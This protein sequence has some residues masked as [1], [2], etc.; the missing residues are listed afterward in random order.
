MHTRIP[1][2][3]PVIAIIGSTGTGK[4]QLAIELATRFKGE[5]INCDAVQM[6]QGLPIITNKVTTEEQ[7]GIPHHLL[8]CI[9]LEEPTWTVGQF[10]PHAMAIIEQI[11]GRGR[12]PILVGGTHYYIQSLLVKDS[13][14]G[15]DQT[16]QPELLD[17]ALDQPTEVLLQKLREVDPIMAE[18]WH[19]NERR[20]IQRS[21]EIWL[22]TG[23]KAS[24][25]YAAQKEP[26]NA[27]PSPSNIT[28]LSSDD[29]SP[30]RYEALLFWMYT[31]KDTLRARLDERVHQMVSAGLVSEVESMH[32]FRN[33][34]ELQGK[35]VDV[36]RGIWVSIGFK[37]FAEY[38]AAI[39]AGR[40]GPDVQKLKDEAIMRTQS[41]TKQY[42]KR[43]IRW[44]EYKFLNAMVRSKAKHNIFVLNSSLT[45]AWHDCVR[46]PAEVVTE[47]FLGA[48][49]VLPEASE[50]FEQSQE[51]LTPKGE[52]LSHSRHRWQKRTCDNCRITATTTE[53]WEKHI[54]SNRHRKVLAGIAKRQRLETERGLNISL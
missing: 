39:A 4:S 23:T 6:Y 41:A 44:I 12:L 53:E 24:D 38:R 40:T 15:N 22:R 3:R 49:S 52:D 33:Q 2:T 54:G 46:K 28:S 32:D 29:E 21:L 20:K 34:Q 5:I 27:S 35:E 31:D 1:P 43:Q 13:I 16:G 36:T 42:A 9:G 11:R 26:P 19:P 10:V 8:G 50:I 14:V 48:S 37:E 51:L 47:M 17:P 25:I 7:H 45:T 18:R 30:L